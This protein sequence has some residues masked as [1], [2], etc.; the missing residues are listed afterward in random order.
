MVLGGGKDYLILAVAFAQRHDSSNGLTGK[1]YVRFHQREQ[2]GRCLLYLEVAGH[3]LEL[4]DQRYG[5][6]ELHVEFFRHAQDNT[7]SLCVKFQQIHLS[8]ATDFAEH[9]RQ[10]SLYAALQV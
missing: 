9:F 6:A 1:V 8:L 3:S 7:L 5:S 4:S 10:R 2:Q